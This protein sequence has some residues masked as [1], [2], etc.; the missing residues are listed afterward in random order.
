[1]FYGPGVDRAKVIT[2]NL[3][4]SW[5]TKLATP[6]D[7]PGNADCRSASSRISRVQTIAASSF[8]CCAK[9]LAATSMTRALPTAGGGAGFGLMRTVPSGRMHSLPVL[10]HARLRPCG[11]NG[12]SS[13]YHTS[14]GKWW[15]RNGGHV[16]AALA[17]KFVTQYKTKMYLQNGKNKGLPLPRG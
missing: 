8:S 10:L 1:M 6:L 4:A 7:P 17:S 3:Y 16:H 13:L 14:D 15:S 11:E 2:S 12:E 9:H 5:V